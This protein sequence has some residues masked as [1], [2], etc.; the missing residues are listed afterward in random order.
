MLFTDR[1]S[2]TLPRW[3]IVLGTVLL[4]ALLQQPFLAADADAALGNSRGPYTDEALYTVQARNAQVT[5][6][7]D[8]AEADGFIKEPLF[9]AASW[10][11]M[12]A[13]AQSMPALR[14]AWMLWGAMVLAALVA[15]PGAW[16]T[17]MRWLLPGAALSYFPFHYAHLAMAEWPATLA[18]LA[19]LAAVHARLNGRGAWALW[20]TGLAVG[21][22]YALKVSF[23]YAAVVPPL[24]F[25]LAL[26]LRPLAGLPVH[27]R[28]WVDVLAAS[29][30]A[31]AAAALYA[32]AWVLPN[33]ALFAS[34][35]GSQTA[36][37]TA[38]LAQLPWLIKT[39]LHTW[40]AEPGVW[41][42]LLLLV[43]GLLAALS[44]WRRS[45]GDAAARQA[46]VAL[47][48]GPL[49][50]CLVEL[51]KFTLPYLPSRYLVSTFMA[52]GLL[53]AAGLA[54]LTLVPRPAANVPPRGWHPAAL[55]G[56][57]LLLLGFNTTFYARSLEDRTHVLHDTQQALAAQGHW[58]GRTVVGPW[59][60]AL[61]WG[62]G[63]V[64]KPVWHKAFNDRDILARLQPA[65]IVT[66][67]DQQD[68]ARA[69]ALDGITLPPRPLM[70]VRV[71]RFDVQVFE[72]PPPARQASR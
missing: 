65:A 62:T 13:G 45:R 37:R 42:L 44:T 24:A 9:A 12:Q 55:A 53:G 52:L 4:I 64:A 14:G 2:R 7:L 10:G 66:E 48:A 50:W 59:A 3:L 61:F 58:Q 6:R 39:Q 33:R 21:V 34:V 20:A 29:G 60:P 26:L 31:C 69:F 8:L 46:W 38:G 23:V 16:G 30:A 56:F 5:G 68:S 57:A 43:V 22:A 19:A 28:Q 67:P 71:Q 27:R 63:A 35:L 1:P 70:Q 17:A 51:H 25:A 15:L 11:W 47:L 49:A 18:V 72:T 54:T 41:P 32:A 36:E 40:L